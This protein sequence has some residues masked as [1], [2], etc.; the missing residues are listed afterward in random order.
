MK[1]KRLSKCKRGSLS[2]P[3]V[4]LRAAKRIAAFRLE[5]YS[6]I[7]LLY[8]HGT[9]EFR[10]QYADLFKPPKK[11]GQYYDTYTWLRNDPD[12]GHAFCGSRRQARN[13]KQWRILALLFM[14]QIT[15]DKD[16]NK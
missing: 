16:W 4:C 11:R 12:M 7:A 14:H 15:K 6:C 13:R 2:E 3:H 8:E 5:G 1:M 10:R 9:P